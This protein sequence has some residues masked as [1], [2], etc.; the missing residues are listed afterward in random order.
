MIK[1]IFKKVRWILLAAFIIIQFFHPEKNSSTTPSPNHI[2]KVFPVPDD[3]QKI[4]DVSCNDCHSNNS[5]YPWYFNIQPVA[6][7]MNDHIEEGKGELNFDEYASYRLRRQYHKF[8]KIAEEVKEDEMPLGSYTLIHRNAI[9]D[10]NQK[11]VIEHWCEAMRDSMKVKY[12][13]D[14]LKR[15]E[16]PGQ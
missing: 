13:A 9:L 14:S 8:E 5:H 16:Q 12:P 1:K 7:W 10:E 2:S 3:V 6:W 4:F 11:Q 15:K